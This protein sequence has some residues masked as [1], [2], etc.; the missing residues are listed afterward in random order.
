[1]TTLAEAIREAV[2]AKADGFISA[3]RKSDGFTHIVA[4]VWNDST[5]EELTQDAEKKV[6]PLTGDSY[7]W[8]IAGFIFKAE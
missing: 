6:S 3:I 5:E 2:E 1:M 4:T 8:E 7:K